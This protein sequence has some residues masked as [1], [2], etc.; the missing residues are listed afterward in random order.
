MSIT[1]ERID[2]IIKVSIHPLLKRDGFLKSART[3]RRARANCIHII[4][5]QGSWTNY[6]DQGQFTVNLAVYFPEAAK[7]H[8]SF[9]ITD[10]PS[11][12][13]CMLTQRIGRLMP[14]H[15]DYWWE[16]D[17][18]SDLDKIAKE[19]ASV[20]QDYGLPW[21]EEHSTLEGAL[22]FALLRK[23]PYWASIFSLLLKNRENAERYLAE[24]IS[25]ATQSPDF[26]SNLMDWGRS[27]GL[28]V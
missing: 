6:D 27:Q 10:H 7:I 2:Y 20:C 16:F 21:L 9:R 17:A 28:V 1:S 8:G 13:D 11:A 26:K 25:N 14:I 23:T 4:N 22:Q 5:V 18:K 24:A 3:F 12:S 15:A 19:A